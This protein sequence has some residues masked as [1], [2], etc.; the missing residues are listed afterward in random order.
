MKALFKKP[1]FNT[2][3]TFFYFFAIYSVL[4]LVLDYFNRLDILQLFTYIA[5]L[6][7]FCY[8][9]NQY[10]SYLLDNRALL[11]KKNISK[12]DKE[13]AAEVSLVERNFKE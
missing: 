13:L 11:A 5:L 6:V 8:K 12:K 4:Y 9:L 3:D 10:F 1:D 2:S 7:F